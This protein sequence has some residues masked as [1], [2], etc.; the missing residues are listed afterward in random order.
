MPNS[1]P[2][3]MDH[4][5]LAI[6]M[7]THSQSLTDNSETSIESANSDGH[8]TSLVTLPNSS[9]CHRR[10][11]RILIM[12]L[13]ILQKVK[14][15]SFDLTNPPHL[16]PLE[17]KIAEILKHRSKE[18]YDD[19]VENVNALLHLTVER[20]HTSTGHHFRMFFSFR[21]LIGEAF[22]PFLRTSIALRLTIR[23]VTRERHIFLPQA[24][25][26]SNRFP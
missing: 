14:Y 24:D 21:T 15:S 1:T 26:G 18:S 7:W 9:A 22:S 16:H 23:N 19:D 8:M 6:W 20:Q 11:G 3:G 10:R 25:G 17:A 5:H 12:K 4:R 2:M 13:V